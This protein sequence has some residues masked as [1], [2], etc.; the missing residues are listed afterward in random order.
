MTANLLVGFSFL[1]AQ[2]SIAQK[3]PGPKSNK[4]ASKKKVSALL[5]KIQEK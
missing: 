4:A 2:G 1:F 5:K 3:I